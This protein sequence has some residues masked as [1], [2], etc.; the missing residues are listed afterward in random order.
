MRTIA[1]IICHSVQTNSP[2]FAGI[3]LTLIQVDLAF[4]SDVTWHANAL[5][6]CCVLVYLARSSVHAD[7]R[8]TERMNLYLFIA[9]FSSKARSTRADEIAHE[10]L[11]AFGV[12]FADSRT[13]LAGAAQIDLAVFAR[14]ARGTIAR[15][16]RVAVD[17][18][19]MTHAGFRQT[20]IEM[21]GKLQ[22]LKRGTCANR[23]LIHVYSSVSFNTYNHR[24]VSDKS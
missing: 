11:V 4:H 18:S 7:I 24:Q 20:V 10:I 15:V 5:G 3:R 19:T 13:A 1:S 6:L 21:S 14:V 8:G 9:M 12:V 16:C 22:L 17:A 23:I 2:I